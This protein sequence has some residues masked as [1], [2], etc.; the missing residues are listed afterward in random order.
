MIALHALE[1]ES[2]G[3]NNNYNVG[4]N[5]SCTTK[6]VKLSVAAIAAMAL[7]S[8]AVNPK[9]ITQQE[10][11]ARIQKDWQA[12]FK[13]QE[14]VKGPLNIY[15]SMARAVKYNLDIR[16]KSMEQAYAEA[17][18]KFAHASMLPSLVGSAGYTSRNNPYSVK[19]P[20]DPGTIS[21]TEDRDQNEA[22][23]QFSWNALDF[24]IS[25][26]ESKQKADLYLISQERKRKILQ[27]VIRDTRYAYWRAW[28]AQKLL[29][30]IR[31]FKNQ[32]KY[33]ISQSKRSSDEKVASPTETAYYRAELWQ[34]FKEMSVLDAQLTKAQPELL[35]MINLKPNSKVV[36]NQPKLTNSPLP[37][38]FPMNSSKLEMM[39]LHNRPELREEDYRQRISKKEVTKATLKMLPNLSLTGGL[40]YDSNSF[41]VNQ[42]WADFG[43]KFSWDILRM[44]SNYQGIKVAKMETKVANIR[45]MALTMAV[46]TQ[47]EIAK[48][49]YKQSVRDVR[50]AENLRNSRYEY[51]KHLS[52]EKKADLSDQLALINAKAKWLVSK[53]GYYLAYAEWRNAGGQLLDSIG[54][55]PLNRVTSLQVPVNNLASEIR[56]SLRSMPTPDT[57]PKKSKITKKTAHN[58]K[59]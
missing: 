23:L 51:Y 31:P 39:A 7:T 50:I 17:D 1:V 8:C 13:G 59:A 19:S 36:L 40:N 18:A 42:R 56:L 16:V 45:R 34:T 52:N 4:K 58:K 54:Y 15:Q 30:Q 43:T 33:A 14:A 6:L 11:A 26:I 27:Q 41:L 55:D 22:S 46:V 12:M 9:I 49:R 3:K 21:T 53:L 57:M 35:A 47:V 25:Y 44:F 10:R 37:K 2:S 28:S 20:S 38:G 48:L 32:I 24:G 29:N 5:M